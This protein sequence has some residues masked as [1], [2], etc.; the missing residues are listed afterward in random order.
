MAVATKLTGFCLRWAEEKDIGLIYDL[1][2]ELAAY[3]SLTHTVHATEE[4]LVDAIFK[5][6]LAEV[7]IGEYEGKPVC[8]ALFYYS[9][10]T[11]IGSP[12]IYIEDLYVQPEMRGKGMG[13]ILLAFLANVAKERRCWGLE[14]ACL[15]WNE[16]SIRFYHRLG[17]VPRNEWTPYR[18]QG[19]EL[20]ALAGRF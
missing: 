5:R 6:R 9:L 3:E 15:D 8:F 20:E 18:L 19:A 12:G 13:A 1:V 2:R 7:V 11:F 16:P 14:W 10:S 17:A 4:S